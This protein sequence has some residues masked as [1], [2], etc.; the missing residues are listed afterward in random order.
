MAASAQAEAEG[1]RAAQTLDRATNRQEHWL[2]RG[3]V[4]IA[5]APLVSGPLVWGA[6]LATLHQDATLCMW[7]AETGALLERRDAAIGVPARLFVWADGVCV[8]CG[9]DG[10]AQLWRC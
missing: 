2:V 5:C 7:D 9:V 8:A 6:K 3:D 10:S 1:W 4:R